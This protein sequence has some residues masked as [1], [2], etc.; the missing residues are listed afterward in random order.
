MK[1]W[2]SVKH[3]F[4]FHRYFGW[5][6]CAVSS[7]HYSHTKHSVLRGRIGNVGIRPC[8]ILPVFAWNVYLQIYGVNM[9]AVI[10][11]IFRSPIGTPLVRSLDSV[12]NTRCVSIC[13]FKLRMTGNKYL[14]PM[15]IF[16][17]NMYV[18]FSMS[19]SMN[20]GYNWKYC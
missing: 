5:L 8:C 10:N 15:C 20:I 17:V 11:A 6:T 12:Q 2:K 1:T 7:Y 13:L 14:R 4:I 9:K 19:N 18:M 16:F 3:M